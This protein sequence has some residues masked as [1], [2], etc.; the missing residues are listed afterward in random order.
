M[1]ADAVQKDAR[2]ATDNTA[3]SAD[4]PLTPQQIVMCVAVTDVTFTRRASPD[5]TDQQVRRKAGCTTAFRIDDL[6]GILTTAVLSGDTDTATFVLRVGKHGSTLAGLT[7]ALATAA[8][9]ALQ[10]GAPLT[11]I[12]DVWRHTRFVPNGRTDDPDVPDTTSLADY[13]ACRLLLDHPPAVA[14]TTA[15]VVHDGRIARR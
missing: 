1:S 10:H 2:Y 11:D 4:K 3:Y 5:S 9:L 7:E 15:T 8:S 13:V 6:A 14:S 12:T